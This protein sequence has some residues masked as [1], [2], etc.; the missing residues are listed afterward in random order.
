MVTERD[1]FFMRKALLLAERGRGRTSPN[2]MVGAVVV[3]RDGVLIGRGAHEFAGGAHA[4]VHALASAGA[5]TIGATLYCTLEPCSYAGRTGPCAPLVVQAGI[6]RV[7]VATEDP[8]PRVAGRG[9]QLLRKHG[10]E[11]ASG[12]LA[13]D[14]ERLNGPFFMIMRARRPFV[15]L[16]IALSADGKVAGATGEP[17]L[18]TSGSANRQVHRDRAETDAIAIG[19]GTVLADDPRLTAR[20][21]YRARRLTRIIFDSRLRTPPSARILR[22]LDAGPVIIIGDPAAAREHPAAVKALQEAGAVMEFPRD[23]GLR[24]VLTGLAER[25]VTAVIVEGG[26][27]LHRAFWDAGLADRVQIYVT[28]H[29]LGDQGVPWM[30][31]E[32]MTSSRVT[33][34]TSRR[35]GVDTLLEAYVHWSD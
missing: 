16:K 1:A 28:P 24:A 18:L 11:V 3:D 17:T 26:P 31:V 23:G 14:A 12:V 7:V 6:A 35:L 13:A 5:G 8:N 4:E 32:V 10:V 19:S 25:G 9:L 20:G 22:T 27:T 15:T 21:A 29:V 34:R 33:A 2:P 30:P